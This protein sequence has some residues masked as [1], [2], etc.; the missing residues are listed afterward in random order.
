MVKD[1]ASGTLGAG[2]GAGAGVGV[3]V[4][5]LG[6][7]ADAATVDGAGFVSQP[8]LSAA[9]AIAIKRKFRP[10]KRRCIR[11]Q[12]IQFQSVC[13][14]H[15]AGPRSSTYPAGRQPINI[16]PLPLMPVRSVA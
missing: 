3:D 12:P 10:F 2:A 15:K 8:V 5:A 7:D 1:F 6:G 16:F 4:E 13:H 11:H 14:S 9:D